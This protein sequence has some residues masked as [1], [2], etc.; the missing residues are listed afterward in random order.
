[1][2]FTR[3]ANA[4]ILLVLDAGIRTHA[5]ARA[6]THTHIHTYTHTHMHTHTYTHRASSGRRNGP[7]TVRAGGH[8]EG[9]RDE[10]ADGLLE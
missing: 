7:G 4:W 3:V 9:G 8:G 1:M 2:A 6:C 5:R 10:S